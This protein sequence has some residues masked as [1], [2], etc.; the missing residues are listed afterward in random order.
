[1][2]ATLVESVIVSSFVVACGHIPYSLRLWSFGI[3]ASFSASAP[4]NSEFVS[5]L[6]HRIM[7]LR[8]SCAQSQVK[9]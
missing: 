6:F 4:V 5:L 9:G 3:Q 8:G 2:Y 7:S 1:M